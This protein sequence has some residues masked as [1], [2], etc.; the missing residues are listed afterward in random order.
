[1]NGLRC[2]NI[3][4][5]ITTKNISTQLIIDSVVLYIGVIAYL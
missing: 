4:P 2:G 1:M 5:A 3:R